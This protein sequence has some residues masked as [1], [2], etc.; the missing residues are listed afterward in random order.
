MYDLV[1]VL[2]EIFG[3]YPERLAVRLIYMGTVNHRTWR[4]DGQPAGRCNKYP[5]RG[6]LR[7]TV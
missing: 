3:P 7:A 1:F 6:P 4:P 2:Y 5:F